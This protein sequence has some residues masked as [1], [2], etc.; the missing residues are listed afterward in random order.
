[1]GAFVLGAFVLGILALLFFGGVNFLRRQQRFVVYFNE[2]I[3]GLNLG[4]QVKVRGVADGRVVALSVRYD[5]ATNQSLS[6]VV[7]EFERNVVVDAKGD[8]VDMSN[9]GRIQALVD[10][11]L[12]AQLGIA[13]LVTS[14]LF[15]ELDF[16]NPVQYPPGPTFPDTK[17]PVIPAVPSTT[18]EFQTAATDILTRIRRIDFEGIAADFKSLLAD[19]RSQVN[20]VDMKALSEQWRKAGASVDALASSPEIRRSFDNLNA[21]LDELRTALSALRGSLATVNTQVGENGRALQATLQRTQDAMVEIRSTALTLRRFVDAQQDLGANA[22]KA[23]VQ[24]AAA[25]DSV[26]KLADYLERNPNALI[27]GRKPPE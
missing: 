6:E 15:V 25:A 2:S 19:A 18:T 24:L 21:T 7:C 4:S 12:R 22:D 26:Q 14:T 8:P 1:V 17:Y 10:R 3:Q 9:R 20:A 16:L 13:G 11:G 27:S 5:T 23:L